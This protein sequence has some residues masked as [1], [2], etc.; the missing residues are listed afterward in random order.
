MLFISVYDILRSFPQL[1]LTRK[2]TKEFQCD[3]RLN[4]DQEYILITQ[5]K[6]QGPSTR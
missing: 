3:S 6:R 5:L 1:R 4:F 2:E